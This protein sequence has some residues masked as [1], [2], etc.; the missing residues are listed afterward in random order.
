MTD[1]VSPP[2]GH[3]PAE[4]YLLHNWD[5]SSPLPPSEQTKSLIAQ[6]LSLP[7]IPR[8]W[9]TVIERF[10]GSILNLRHP[11]QEEITNILAPWRPQFIRLVADTL[12]SNRSSSVDITDDA[13]WV[14]THYPT[15]NPDAAETASKRWRELVNQS[16]MFYTDEEIASPKRTLND[17][18]LFNFLE[19]MPWQE[20]VGRVLM[21]L[22]ELATSVEDPYSYSRKT[23]AEMTKE[24]EWDETMRKGLREWVREYNPVPTDGTRMEEWQRRVMSAYEVKKLQ[25]SAINRGFVVADRRMFETGEPL[26]LMLDVNGDIVR[27]LRPDERDCMSFATIS[28]SDAQRCLDEHAYFNEE[29]N[30]EMCGVGEK[31][32]L[33]G[34]YGDVLY[35]LGDL[36]SER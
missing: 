20:I 7:T 36:L 11:T 30:P 19:E 12:F 13:V 32:Q 33:R 31:Y 4:Q 29:E 28:G 2:W 14:R 24:S 34:V 25:R 9:D 17:T 5:H 23:I 16:D 26:F 10:D 22:P 21:L 1:K 35:G 27:W 6:F 18:G 15:D 8:E 3:L